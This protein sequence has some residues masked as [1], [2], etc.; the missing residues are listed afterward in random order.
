MSQKFVNL[1]VVLRFINFSHGLMKVQFIICSPKISLDGID[2]SFSV[3]WNLEIDFFKMNDSMFRFDE[4]SVEVIFI[5]D[6]EQN[7]NSEVR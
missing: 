6:S 5:H 2:F 3:C 4:L 1:F 7:L